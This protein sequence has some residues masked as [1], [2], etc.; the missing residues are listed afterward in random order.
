MKSLCIKVAFDFVIHYINSFIQKQLQRSTEQ[1]NVMNVNVLTHEW[2]TTFKCSVSFIL[3]Y[4]IFLTL[5]VHFN[6]DITVTDI[7]TLLDYGCHRYTI[8]DLPREK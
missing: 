5:C 1:N 6:F 8:L 4:K 7:I 2:N 3:F